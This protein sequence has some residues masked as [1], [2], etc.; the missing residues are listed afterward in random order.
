MFP[1]RR[2]RVKDRSMEPEIREG[3]HVLVN[4]LSYV[5]SRPR[6]GDVVVVRH[7]EEGR[8]LVKRIVRVDEEGFFILGDN[9]DYSVDSRQFGPVPKELIIGR[10]FLR[11]RR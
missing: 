2:F 4:R 5:L 3:D 1:L 6:E 9:R 8:Y 7:P 11:L 10:V